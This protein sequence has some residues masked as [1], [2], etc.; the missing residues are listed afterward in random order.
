MAERAAAIGVAPDGRA[1]TVAKSSGLPEF[2][3]GWK[4]DVEI[5]EAVVAG[6]AGLIPRFRE[7]IA[8]TDRTDLVTQGLL[9]DVT[10]KL[11]EARWM[12][13]AQLAG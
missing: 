13:Q 10:G 8:E 5:I 4:T 11:E 3:E 6:L 1:A 2:G 9:I 12:W 7:R